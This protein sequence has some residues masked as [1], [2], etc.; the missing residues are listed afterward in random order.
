[1]R[2]KRIQIALPVFFAFAVIL[3]MFVGYKLHSNMPISKSFFG[4]DSKNKIDEVMDLIKQRYVDEIGLDTT[5]DKAIEQ[6]L[7]DLDPHSI[8]IHASSLKEVNED[9]EGKFEGIGIEF[10]VFNDTVH[11]L[12]VLSNGPASKAGI[13]IGDK[14]LAVNDSVATGKIKTDTFKS[15]VKGPGGSIVKIKFERDHQQFIKEITRGVIP[16]YAIDASYLVDKE[17]GLSLIHI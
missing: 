5:S 4:A 14:I 1:M 10:N 8:Y 15:W 16:I 17:T 13:K 7:L 9:L 12:S 2:N 11:V 3:G 6:I